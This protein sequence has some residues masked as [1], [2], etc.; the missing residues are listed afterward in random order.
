MFDGLA[1]SPY[2]HSGDSQDLGSGTAM[3]AFL[4][5][6]GGGFFDN[7]GHDKSPQSV[8]TIHKSGILLGTPTELYTQL[9]AWRS[10]VGIRGKL[11]ALWD[12]GKL[13]WKW[14]ST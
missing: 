7:F 4:S 2:V 10:K 12:D 11:V 6:P 13:R 14:R 9:Q 1:L 5:L 8:Q 3:T